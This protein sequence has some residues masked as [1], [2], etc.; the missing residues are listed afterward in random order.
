MNSTKINIKTPHFIK[1]LI[2]FKILFFIF[3]PLMSMGV[4]DCEKPIKDM[5]KQEK[6]H[7]IEELIKKAGKGSKKAQYKLGQFYLKAKS[8]DRAFDW[9]RRAADQGDADSQYK[10][11]QMYLQGK[12]VNQ[13][14]AQA[15]EFFKKA[16]EQGHAEAQYD[17]AQ[18]YLK[19]SE[20]FIG[21]EE[22]LFKVIKK[23]KKI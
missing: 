19:K 21:L 23:L 2:K 22:Q 4:V 3:V 15:F 16:A 7:S 5:S 1:K 12:G 14:D 18:M 13:S 8:Y 17:F 6:R 10:L 20:L 9:L 11:A